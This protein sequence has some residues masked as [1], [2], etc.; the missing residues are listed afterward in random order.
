MTVQRR[1]IV[2]V[3]WGP[4]ACRKAIL[5][6]GQTL[7]IGRSNLAD[8]SLPCDA[9]MSARHLALTW[10]GQRCRVRDLESAGGTWVEG[11]RVDEGE[12]VNG[13]WIRA[14]E[15]NLMVYLE[16]HTSPRDEDG[17]AALAEEKAAALHALAL[18][19]NLFGSRSSASPVFASNIR[20]IQANSWN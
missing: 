14:G 2:E 4:L 10:D 15:T 20:L 3:R 18:E 7:C 12:I 5:T 17:A 8:L 6:P 11:E 9:R 16:A 19:A 13:A 1:A